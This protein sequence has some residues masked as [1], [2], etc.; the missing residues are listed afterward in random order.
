MCVVSISC[1]KG[2]SLCGR[3]LLCFRFILPPTAGLVF[4]V[5]GP[6]LRDAGLVIFVHRLGEGFLVE[7]AAV[8]DDL[9]HPLRKVERLI[10]DVERLHIVT[11]HQQDVDANTRASIDR[12]DLADFE[13]GEPP[14]SSKSVHRIHA[15]FSVMSSGR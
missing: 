2:L 5:I 9:L 11:L 6:G 15:A 3:A 1:F 13:I 12:A 14:G 10:G 8:A 7:D 4:G